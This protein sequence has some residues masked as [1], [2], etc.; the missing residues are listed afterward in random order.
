MIR[1]GK[2]NPKVK[3]LSR[4]S[5]R[6]YRE[7]E[8][9]FIVEGRRLVA[10]A[11][12][13]SW[14][15]E[16]IYATPG[17]VVRE[18]HNLFSLA[19][20]RRIPWYE[21]PEEIFRRLSATEEPQGVLAVVSTRRVEFAELLQPAPPLLIVVDALQ[22]PGNLGTIVRTAQAAGATGMLL[23]AGTVDLFNPKTVRATAGALFRLPV[24][25]DLSWEEAQ[26]FLGEAGLPLIVADPQGEVPLYRADFRGPVAI[27]VGS[28]GAGL[29]PEVRKAATRRVF[30]PMPGGAESLNVAV[31]AALLLYE[32]VRQRLGF[33]E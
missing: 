15:V 24:V 1:L 27:A 17:F 8:G 31:A 11:L 18:G 29:R 21:L 2:H 10:E 3:M 20:A 6:R 9:K 33:A 28:E 7:K 13:S 32:A 25:Q 4:L 16:G 26:K 22:D 5:Q 14:P 23:L 30:I 19:Q 12:A